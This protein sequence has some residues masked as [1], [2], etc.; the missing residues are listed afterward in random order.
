MQVE[1]LAEECF[2]ETAG[3]ATIIQVQ[4]VDVRAPYSGAHYETMCRLRGIEGLTKARLDQL[5]GRGIRENSMSSTA[6]L[7]IGP[8]NSDSVRQLICG[9]MPKYPGVLL[10]NGLIHA[11]A[12]GLQRV[13]FA[14]PDLR[15]IDKEHIVAG[16]GP[17]IGLRD[18]IKLQTDDPDN[19]IRHL[20]IVVEYNTTLAYW[21]HTELGLNRRL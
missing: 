17:E 21:V 9:H 2:Y 12:L 20:S 16:F 10:Q 3:D 7:D 11:S 1:V 5:V 6:F 4:R 15:F 18:V 8:S 14:L 13:V 19:N